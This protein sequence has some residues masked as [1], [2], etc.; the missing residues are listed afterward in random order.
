MSGTLGAT[1]AAALLAA[2]VLTACGAASAPAQPAGPAQ[3]QATPGVRQTTMPTGTPARGY[4][5]Y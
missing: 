2:V 1:L 5:G 3:I 4:D